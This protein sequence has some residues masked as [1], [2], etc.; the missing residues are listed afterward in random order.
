MLNSIKEK[1][2][3]VYH[4]LVELNKSEFRDEKGRYMSLMDN[5]EW[6]QDLG[7][8]TLGGIYLIETTNSPTSVH[9]TSLLTGDDII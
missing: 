1:Y 3:D 9:I 8:Y 2:P 6:D 5:L 7:A 4:K